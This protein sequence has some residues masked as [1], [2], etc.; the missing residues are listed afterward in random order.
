MFAFCNLRVHI[1]IP[2]VTIFI[3]GCNIRFFQEGA[4]VGDWL[5]ANWENLM[6]RERMN[7]L[8]YEI[9]KEGHLVE[10]QS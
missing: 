3:P 5:K 9:N 10:A 7:L 6:P 8:G 4:M 1:S 2:G